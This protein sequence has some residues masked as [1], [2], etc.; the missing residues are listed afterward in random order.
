M[1]VWSSHL[2][3]DALTIFLFHGV[4]SRSSGEVRNYTRK[5]L[6]LDEF[7]GIIRDLRA[8][9]TP[10]SMPEVVAY[11]QA[12]AP[13]PARAFAITFD[14]G[15]RNN[16]A[17]AA[18]VLSD[19]RVPGTFYVTTDFIDSNGASWIDLIEFAVERTPVVRLDVPAIGLSGSWTTPTEKR[20]LLDRVRHAV[21]TDRRVDPAEIVAAIWRQTGVTALDPDP[22]L[23]QKMSWNEVRALASDPLFTVGGHSHT[24]RILE[25]LP[26]PE[27]EREVETSL[28]LLGAHLPGRVEHYSYPEGLAHCYSDR[29]IELLRGHGI[30]CSPS[31]E[32]GVNAPGADLFRLKRVMVA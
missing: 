15:F 23:D 7:A 21:K 16:H 14:D 25:F 26:Q 3:D 20:A 24:H 12:R 8:H 30:R 2:R 31:A 32:P 22:E 13:W 18:P 17:L 19:L 5:H 11:S 29:V 27:L 28:S 4:V 1:M 9:G 10:L 6:P